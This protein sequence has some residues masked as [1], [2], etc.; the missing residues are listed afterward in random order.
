MSLASLVSKSKPPTADGAQA[1]E[2]AGRRE[3]RG[4][5]SGTER[6][7]QENFE[8]YTK[9]VKGMSSEHKAAMAGGLCLLAAGL[10]AGGKYVTKKRKSELEHRNRCLISAYDHLLSES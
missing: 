10:L 4:K 2:P 5:M 8:H 1:D 6:R 3:K 7:T 9:K